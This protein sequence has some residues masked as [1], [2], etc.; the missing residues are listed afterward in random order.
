MQNIV[1]FRTVVQSLATSMPPVLDTF[2]GGGMTLVQKAC[3]YGL[4]GFLACLLEHGASP[5][6]IL[7]DNT[8]APVLL[9]AY[10]G[11]AET[12]SVLVEHRRSMGEGAGVTLMAVD[13]VTGASALHMVLEM[14]QRSAGAGR[15]QGYRD[16]LNILLTATVLEQEVRLCINKRDIL[17]NTPLHYAT[18]AWSQDTVRSLLELGANIGLKNKI[19]ETPIQRILPETMED[20]LDTFCLTAE[21]DIHQQEFKLNF[22]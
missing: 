18:Q 6:A 1:F 13:K 8:D 15:E 7:R 20:F 22:K 14:P 17:G 12:L 5:T 21:H 4:P 2:S 10:G 3:S 16:S 19:G 9:A 11:H